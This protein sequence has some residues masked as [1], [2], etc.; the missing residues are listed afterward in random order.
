MKKLITA[1]MVLSLVLFSGSMLAKAGHGGK[2]HKSD[3]SAK[4][5]KS[6]KSHKRHKSHKS[7]KSKRS[8][9]S[10]QSDKS[11]D[12]SCT[13]TLSAPIVISDDLGFGIRYDVVLS[14]FACSATE[15]DATA[16]ALLADFSMDFPQIFEFCET[17]NEIP[18]AP[19]KSPGSVAGSF[20]VDYAFSCLF[21]LF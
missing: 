1:I 8:D 3:K 18:N 5:H 7:K 21:V 2:S 19:N 14:G 6:G 20:D 11:G 4:S 12:V 17:N 10:G 9:K 15:V 16:T 13:A